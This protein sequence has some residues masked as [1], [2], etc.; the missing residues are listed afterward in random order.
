MKNLL[1]LLLVLLLFTTPCHAQYHVIQGKPGTLILLSKNKEWPFSLEV[2]GEK[3]V[4]PIGADKAPHPYFMADGRFLQVVSVAL[5]QFNAN[6]KADDETLLKQQ[7]QYESDYHKLP[8]NSVKSEIKKLPSGR[9]VLVWSFV[10]KQAPKEQ[11]FVSLREKNYII[12]LGSA[13]DENDTKAAV[14]KFLL[15]TA[16]TFLA[17][18]K[19]INLQFNPDGSYKPKTK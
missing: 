11:V 6:P 4:Q 10:P 19:P 15:Q 12:M 18:D 9:S 16:S 2:H 17:Y 13:V 1:F 7:L 8:P 5:S 14:D 3:D